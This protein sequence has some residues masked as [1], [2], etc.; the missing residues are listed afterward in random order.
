MKGIVLKITKN[1]IHSDTLTIETIPRNNWHIMVD[2]GMRYNISNVYD[3][4][5]SMVEP[6]CAQF[7]KWRQLTSL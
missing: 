7:E 5:S 3:T 2:E 1:R 4:K 6:T